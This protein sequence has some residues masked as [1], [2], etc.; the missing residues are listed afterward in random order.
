MSVVPN[1]P[2]PR[3]NQ[4]EARHVAKKAYRFRCCV[5]CGLEIPTCLT[6]AH[7]DQN[8]SNNTPDNLAWL[9]WTHHWM[10]DVGFYPPQAIKL[11]RVHWQI[12][13]GVPTHSARMKDAGKK[14]AIKRKHRAAARKA[15][16]TRRGRQRRD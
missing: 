6:V 12:T 13:R 14:A 10:Y 1:A 11:L 7:L 4:S 8:S 3:R 16:E 9:C 5:I 15:V 2:V